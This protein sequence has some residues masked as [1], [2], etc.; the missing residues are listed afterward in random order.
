[1]MV[2]TKTIIQQNVA[3]FNIGDEVD[4]GRREQHL[5]TFIDIV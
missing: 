3:Y 4:F 5:K 1:M 2:K